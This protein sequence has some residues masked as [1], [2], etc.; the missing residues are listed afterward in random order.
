[1]T[2]HAA[3][4]VS[5][6]LLGAGVG[7]AAGA[8]RTS[9]TSKQLSA[10]VRHEKKLGPKPTP[11]WYWRWTTWQ[12]GEGYARNHAH[13]PGLRPKRAPRLIPHWAWRRLHFFLLARRARSLATQ[14]APIPPRQ[15]GGRSGIGVEVYNNLKGIAD[16]NLYSMV[17]GG[18]S[19]S[20]AHALQH[21]A[22]RSLT[23]F[24]AVD[25][26]K[27]FTT[28]VTYSQA[29]SHGWLLKSS[30]GSYLM[31]PAFSTYCADVGSHSYQ[32]AWINYV[33]GY[34]AAHPGIKG[35]FNDNTLSDPK[36]DCGAYPAKYPSTATWSA[37]ML[38]FVK[39]AYSAL[40]AHGYYLALNAGAY[41]PGDRKFTDGTATINW[42]KQVGHYS[43][44]LMNENYDET[45]GTTKKLRAS[46]AAWY[47]EWDG[48]Q[49]LIPTAQSMGKD[50]IGLTY[51][52]CSN[53]AAMT[54]AKASFLLAWNGGGSVLMYKCGSSDP[55]NGAWTASI[56]TP[57]GPKQHVGVGWQ[58]A[59]TGG[60]VLV[61][62]SATASQRFTVSG[63]SYTLGPTTARI[64][65]GS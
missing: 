17:I 48:W 57:A 40:H 52:S 65:A 9:S 14:H 37:A 32:Q 2:K 49:R 62:P 43:D 64:V 8:M 18:S 53:T 21:A 23:Y 47:Q 22:G 35:V 39:A 61:N 7:S 55:T 42:W 20:D 27:S 51:Q 26:A 30:T 29:Y 3:L 46:G 34:L 15:H 45:P 12:L 44:G 19:A 1:M 16:L 5:M 13:Q 56:G 25:V 36:A 6:I 31:N 60:T 33:L 24:D 10:A 58:R 38:S 28:G 41:I 54:Y 50:F 63:R 4:V 11:Q 59:Y